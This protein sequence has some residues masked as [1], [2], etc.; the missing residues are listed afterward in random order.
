MNIQYPIYSTAAAMPIQPPQG[1]ADDECAE[2]ARGEWA[3]LSILLS[4]GMGLL[5][6]LGWLLTL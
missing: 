1:Q 6:F 2:L 5:W 3:S 4:T